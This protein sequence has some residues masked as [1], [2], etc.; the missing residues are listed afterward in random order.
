MLAVTGWCSKNCQGKVDSFPNVWGRVDRTGK[1]WGR[2]DSWQIHCVSRCV[3]SLFSCWFELVN[4]M[5]WVKVT[6]DS[7]DSVSQVITIG[8][9]WHQAT[10]ILWVVYCIVL[11]FLYC[12]VHDDMFRKGI[13]DPVFLCYFSDMKLPEGQR[14]QS[15]SRNLL[16]L[17]AG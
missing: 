3:I 1:T 15:L 17:L 4:E 5:G 2:V 7:F 10:N 13:G 9:K 14:G 6:K 8:V 11:V 16:D 12:T